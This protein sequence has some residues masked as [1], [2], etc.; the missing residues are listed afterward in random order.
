MN[1]RGPR[2]RGLGR[3]GEVR[4]RPTP[5]PDSPDRVG[6]VAV[7]DERDTAGSR[8]VWLALGLALGPAVGLGCGHELQIAIQQRITESIPHRARRRDRA[9]QARKSSHDCTLTAAHHPARYDTN[10][11]RVLGDMGPCYQ[12][13]W[14]PCLKL[15]K[16]YKCAQ[17]STIELGESRLV[18]GLAQ[19]QSPK[20]FVPPA[21]TGGDKRDFGGVVS[22]SRM[23]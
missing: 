5:R 1:V 22:I 17:I 7:A 13:R 16:T 4:S 6:P 15:Q 10:I 12:F 18:C 14:L 11:T 9:H 8:A 3:R 21:R 23:P 2:A 19:I 20:P